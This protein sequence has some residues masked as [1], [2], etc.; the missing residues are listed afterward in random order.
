[1]LIV[2]SKEREVKKEGGLDTGRS[3]KK[4]NRR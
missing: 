3:G 1:M 4:E 2:H